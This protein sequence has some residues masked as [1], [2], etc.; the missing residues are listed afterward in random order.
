MFILSS[1]QKVNGSIHNT[2]SVSFLGA[3]LTHVEAL[4]PT[5]VL[6]NWPIG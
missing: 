6:L 4:G 1:N 3:E 5:T 2:K